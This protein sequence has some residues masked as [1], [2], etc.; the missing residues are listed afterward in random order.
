MPNA[1]VLK[2]RLTL[3]GRSLR[4]FTFAKD[5]V[6]VGRDPD[7]D[8]FLDNPGVSRRHARIQRSQ[9]GEFSIEDLG[10]A[11]GTFLNDQPMKRGH[12]RSNDVV[13]IGK[14]SLWITVEQNRP[15]RPVGVVPDALEGTT[16]LTNDQLAR[17]M[18]NVREAESEQPALEVVKNLEP[19]YENVESPAQPQER[20]MPPA[21][22]QE[23]GE[24]RARRPAFVVVLGVVAAFL[25]GVAIGVGFVLLSLRASGMDWLLK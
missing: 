12:L 19:A 18:T 14:F 17:M 2:I 11:N 16:I 21:Q 4:S 22:V 25:F 15:S 7:A 3:K 6:T 24:P 9:A 10:S 13:N 1:P 8:I 20:V 23:E 5:A